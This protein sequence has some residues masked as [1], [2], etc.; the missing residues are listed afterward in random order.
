MRTMA[1][2]CTLSRAN[3]WSGDEQR[4]A[5]NG[6]GHITRTKIK[7]RCGND[8][9]SATDCLGWCVSH[10]SRCSRAFVSQLINGRVER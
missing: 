4:P 3:E 9:W 7:K 6:H 5:E 10:Q 8:F 1:A 2:R